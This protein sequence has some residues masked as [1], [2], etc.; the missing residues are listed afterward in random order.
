MDHS[1]AISTSANLADIHLRVLRELWFHFLCLLPAL[2]SDEFGGVQS[3]PCSAQLG[4][5]ERE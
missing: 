5:S 4:L 1:A 3:C 2:E